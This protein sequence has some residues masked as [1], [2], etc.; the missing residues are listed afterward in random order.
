MSGKRA[1]KNMQ[2]LLMVFFWQNV[3]KN[4]DY[5]KSVYS[6]RFCGD[7]PSEPGMLNFVW[8]QIMNMPRNAVV[9][10]YKHG[11]GAKL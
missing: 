1:S 10:N 9:T 4:D 5:L 11:D 2:L 3:K 8:V 6:F 7:E